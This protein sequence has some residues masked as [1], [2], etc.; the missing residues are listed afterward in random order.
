MEVG[1]FRFDVRCCGGEYPV[2][3]EFIQSEALAVFSTDQ[4]WF[5]RDVLSV[6]YFEFQ[7]FKMRY[8]FTGQVDL[9]NLANLAPIGTDGH[10][11]PSEVFV[12][13]G[14][15]T[16]MVVGE[17]REG[18]HNVVVIIIRQ[19]GVPC[20]L[21][22]IISTLW[23]WAPVGFCMPFLKFCFELVFGRSANFGQMVFHH[24]TIG[25]IGAWLRGW[26]VLAGMSGASTPTT[27]CLWR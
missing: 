8:S 9:A 18:M 14:Q 26:T 2:S 3:V 15:V 21:V 23:G 1:L 17:Y 12:V 11:K 20:E 19:V 16:M 22:D 6:Y 27:F 7:G 4:C 24:V 5:S 13:L 10:R 25:A